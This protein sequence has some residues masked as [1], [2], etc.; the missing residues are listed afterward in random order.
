MSG[1]INSGVFNVW[2]VMDFGWRP[3]P[4]K[5]EFQ[6]G[7]DFADDLRVFNKA[8]DPHDAFTFGTDERISFPGLR[9][10]RLQSSESAVPSFS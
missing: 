5:P 6:V 8:D 9:R 3:R 10:D 4:D 2:R 1:I 7:E